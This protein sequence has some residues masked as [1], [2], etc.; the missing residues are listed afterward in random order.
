MFN[1]S[2]LRSCALLFK[3]YSGVE[4]ADGLDVAGSK[5]I[6]IPYGDER[7]HLQIEDGDRVKATVTGLRMPH[8]TTPFPLVKLKEGPGWM[9]VT[10]LRMFSQIF[11][12]LLLMRRSETG[13]WTSC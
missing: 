4:G 13:R 3:S 6:M 8:V 12:C 2:P 10:M 5:T 11:A 7:F 1:C 9:Y